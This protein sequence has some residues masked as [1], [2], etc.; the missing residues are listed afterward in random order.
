[1]LWFTNTPTPQM[2]RH[3]GTGSEGYGGHWITQLAEHVASVNEIE[4]GIVTAYPDLREAHFS[5][6]G[7]EYFVIPQPSRYPAFGMRAIDLE[8]CL[9]AIEQ[10]KPDLIHIHGSERFYGLIKVTSTI[11]VPVLISIQGLLGPFSMRRH[12]FGTLS[13][14]EILKSIRLIELPVRYGL[15]WQYYDA[16]K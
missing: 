13:L 1:M 10:F 16:W 5:E 11:Q 8:K 14:F 4:L 15:A 6:D 3:A 12:F 9:A 7:V 2:A